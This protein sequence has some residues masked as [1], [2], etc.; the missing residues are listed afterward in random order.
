MQQH[1]RL[2]KKSVICQK[3]K[4]RSELKL[5]NSKLTQQYGPGYGDLSIELQ[6]A[7]L[8]V[9]NAS[10]SLGIF[11]KRRIDFNSSHQNQLLLLW[12]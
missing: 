10:K 5:K 8:K 9:L 12:E 7:I 2:L 4:F 6:P 1:Q 11:Y 3:N